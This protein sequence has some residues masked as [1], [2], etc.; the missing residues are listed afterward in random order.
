LIV[1]SDSPLRAVFVQ[2]VLE[3]GH[4]KGLD[5]I[6]SAVIDYAPI[7]NLLK[8]KFY[9]KVMSLVDVMGKTD[10]DKLLLLSLLAK[11]DGRAGFG[12]NLL[13]LLLVQLSGGK[14]LDHDLMRL[15]LMR[16]AGTS[17]GGAAEVLLLQHL[18]QGVPRVRGSADADRPQAPA[19]R[20]GGA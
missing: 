8:V 5:P 7:A 18:A 1:I 12:E 14:V 11:G 15:L 16:S 6:N 2:E 20:P 13:P 9:V 17:A 10:E 4:L 19:V 3:N